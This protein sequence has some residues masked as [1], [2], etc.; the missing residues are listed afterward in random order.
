MQLVDLVLDLFFANDGL[1]L[2]ILEA[3]ENSFMILLHLF[4]LLLLLLK[5][6]LDEFKLLVANS[7]VFEGLT[8]E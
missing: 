7:L 5:L 1:T 2:I 4:L 6:Q 3:L 8:L